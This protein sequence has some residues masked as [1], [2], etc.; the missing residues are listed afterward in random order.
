MQ[1]SVVAF[2]LLASARVRSTAHGLSLEFFFFW[3]WNDSPGCDVVFLFVFFRC[4]ICRPF[5]FF[6]MAAGYQSLRGLVF[7]F[8]SFPFLALGKEYSGLPGPFIW[9]ISFAAIHQ[10]WFRTYTRSCKAGRKVRWEGDKGGNIMAH[11][12][13]FGLS[14]SYQEASISDTY[15]FYCRQ[16]GIPAE[17]LGKEAWFATTPTARGEGV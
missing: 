10:P 1:P 12:V 9:V 14:S 17:F 8:F 6:S 5:G 7:F 2:I 4:C 15:I 16:G 11:G 3:T 13:A